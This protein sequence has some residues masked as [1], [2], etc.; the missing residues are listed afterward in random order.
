MNTMNWI[1]VKDR[2]P[3]EQYKHIDIL[4]WVKDNLWPNRSSVA[5][6]CYCF[7]EKSFFHAGCSHS[8]CIIQPDGRKNS[9]DCILSVTRMDYHTE[10]THWM[11]LPEGPEDEN[12]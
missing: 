1:S 12:Q 4:V 5:Y 9:D 6:A 3:D 11:S 8:E 2:L 7:D 10:V